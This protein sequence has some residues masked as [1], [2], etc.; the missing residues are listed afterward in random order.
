V[1][2]EDYE[3]LYALLFVA[4]ISWSVVLGFI[5]GWMMGHVR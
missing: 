1:T 5:T 3:A 2:H 4:F